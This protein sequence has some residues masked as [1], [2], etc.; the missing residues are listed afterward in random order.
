[1]RR[2]QLPDGPAT[3]QPGKREAPS[4]TRNAGPIA[5]VLARVLPAQGTVLEIAS[6]TGQHIAQFAA[7]WPGVH[8]QPSDA[9]SQNFA[10]I[11]AWTDEQNA[12]NLAA[13]VVLDACAP[14]W[15]ATWPDRDVITLTNLLHLIST[16]EAEILLAETAQALT[17]GG[18][19]CLYGPFRQ[20]GVLVSE[21]DRNFDASLR[22]QDPAIGYKDIEWVEQ[23]LGAHGLNRVELIEMPANNLMLVTRRA[24]D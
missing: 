1:M 18:V 14:G 11:T 21:G 7:R 19:F 6:G 10:S 17:P 3:E 12:P 13:P 22:A 9:N 5:E 24:A 15:S 20:N 2:L 16:P 4:A 8:W 23:V